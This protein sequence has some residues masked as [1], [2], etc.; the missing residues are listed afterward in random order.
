MT[1]DPWGPLLLFFV[2]NTVQSLATG[3][4]FTL[5]NIVGLGVMIVSL[6][7]YVGLI[8]SGGSDVFGA[9]ATVAAVA[10]AAA[11]GLF[12]GAVTTIV[13]SNSLT[14]DNPI[15]IFLNVAIGGYAIFGAIGSAKPGAA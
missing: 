9:G 4:A 15:I 13:V 3:Q 14:F 6:I 11:I 2:A 8:G 10:R 7:A 5:I 1:S 12:V